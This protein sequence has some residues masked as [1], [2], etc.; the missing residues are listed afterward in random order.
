M[1]NRM[2]G[3]AALALACCGATRPMDS[4]P[5]ATT[6]LRLRFVDAQRRPV[7]ISKA[8]LLL[9]AW[10]D[11][12]RLTLP[13]QGDR[14]HLDLSPS[15]L[16][17]R[18]PR[19]FPDLMRAYLYVQAEGYAPI[20]S[21]PFLWLGSGAGDRRRDAGSV[22]IGFRQGR[23][24][25]LRD[26]E[27]AERTITLRRPGPRQVTLADEDGRPLGGAR[28]SACMFWSA[29]NHCGVLSGAEPLGVFVSDEEGRLTLP[30]GDFEYAL[31]LEESRSAFQLPPGSEVIAR[32]QPLGSLGRGDYRS[33]LISFLDRPGT[34]FCVHRFARRPLH[35]RI[36]RAG[37]PLPHVTVM[38][39]V[40]NCCA[41]CSGPLGTSDAMGCIV[42][43]DFYPEEI[44]ELFIED[45][46]GTGIWQMSCRDLPAGAMEID[47]GPENSDRR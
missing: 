36:L 15:W 20:R 11:A 18:W 44:E 3:I 31:M 2:F 12:D 26:G 4:Q 34:T 45:P 19:R 43:E 6:E 8:E 29:S 33:T 1:N 42:V 35:T 13:V 17:A 21:E 10:G 25:S 14:L 27:R 5:A 38:K 39:S 28:V 32:I 40:S 30:D 47:L 9:V 23:P 16:R 41:A 22:T 46:V 37:K 7:Q 24:A